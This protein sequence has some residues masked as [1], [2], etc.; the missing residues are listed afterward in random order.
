MT[1]IT[2][3]TPVLAADLI[4]GREREPVLHG[5][6]FAIAVGSALVL[7]PLAMTVSLF[8]TAVTLAALVYAAA[9]AVLVTYS[10]FEMAIAQARGDV[11]RVSLTD[12]AMALFPLVA[13]AIAAVIFQPTATMLVGAWAAGALVTATIQLTGALVAGQLVLRR[14]WGLAASITRRSF[15]L[16]L[17]NGTALLVSRIDVLVVAAVISASAAGVYSIPVALSASLL[18][19]SRA[20]LTA[21]YHSIMTAPATEV[22]ARLGAALRHSVI[23]VLVGGSLSIPFVA[24][25]AGFVFGGAYSEIWRPYAILVPASA[26][27]CMIEVLRHFLVTRLERQREFLFTAVGMLILNGVL[28]VVGAAEFGLLGAAASTTITYACAALVLVA[29]CARWLSVSMLELA[30]PRRSDLGAYWRVLRPLLARLRP[31]DNR[32]R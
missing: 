16:A 25:G 29:F 17:A 10:N 28:A 18:L 12:I 9:I 6:S 1:I 7:I 32:P 27:S 24:V 2:G 20:L 23:V 5:A 4:H 30:L 21:T 8:T 11:L 14:A 31:T 26:F 19:L 15:R 13:T 22:G 3:G